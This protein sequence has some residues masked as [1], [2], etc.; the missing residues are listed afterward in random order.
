MAKRIYDL[1]LSEIQAL[2]P[3]AGRCASVPGPPADKAGGDTSAAG[4]TSLWN[5][6]PLC[7]Q[8]SVHSQAA[9]EICRFESDKDLLLKWANDSF[10]CM[11]TAARVRCKN[12]RLE[13]G[14]AS[15]YIADSV[16]PTHGS[17]VCHFHFQACEDGGGIDVNTHEKHSN[18]LMSHSQRR[19]TEKISSVLSLSIKLSTLNNQRQHQKVTTGLHTTPHKAAQSKTL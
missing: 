12:I 17:T 14:R 5:I 11:L 3:G 6:A 4:C 16:L 10:D 8:R 13:A 18:D 1:W 15:C 19:T 2:P 7:V 9:M